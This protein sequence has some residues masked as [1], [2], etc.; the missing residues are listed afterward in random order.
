MLW[1]NLCEG[2]HATARSTSKQNDLQILFEERHSID[3]VVVK[4]GCSSE[5]NKRRHHKGKPAQRDAPEKSVQN[6]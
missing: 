1:S 6:K 2:I 4:L 3:D 5:G